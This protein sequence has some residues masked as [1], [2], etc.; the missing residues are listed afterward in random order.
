MNNVGKPGDVPV[1]PFQTQSSFG[2]VTGGL[3][4]RRGIHGFLDR[5]SLEFDEETSSSSNS[6]TERE[7]DFLNSLRAAERDSK[8]DG[9]SDK[10][11]AQEEQGSQ[12]QIIVVVEQR[13]WT[14]LPSPAGSAAGPQAVGSSTE[15]IVNSVTE[16]IDRSIRA[17]LAPRPGE[18]LNLKIA[19]HEESMG[20]AGL[21][22]IVTPTTLDVVFER[23]GG[24]FSEELV[25]AAQALAER[26]MTRFSKRTVRIL[27]T[28]PSSAR[29]DQDASA[30]VVNPPLNLFL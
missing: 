25:R 24:I 6:A 17:E 29:D 26:L 2:G 27:D 23:T 16:A 11:S 9:G 13:A 5:D 7:T 20:L 14:G 18:P 22:I 30:T 3:G 28:A 4:E 19:F 12:S 21:H 15:S 8:N 1:N 10:E